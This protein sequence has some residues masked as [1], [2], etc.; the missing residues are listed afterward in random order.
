[1]IQKNTNRRLQW[2]YEMLWNQIFRM[3]PGFVALTILGSWKKF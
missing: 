3:K 2:Y 1:M